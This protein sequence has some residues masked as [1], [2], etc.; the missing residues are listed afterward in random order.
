MNS[1]IDLILDSR[2]WEVFFDVFKTFL[3]FSLGLLSSYKINKWNENKKKKRLKKFYLSWISFSLE[4]FDRQIVLL[5]DYISEFESSNTSKL[6][7]NNSQIEKLNSINN[8]DLFDVFVLSNKGNHFINSQNLHQL[9]GHIEYL[10]ISI[11]NVK[12]RFY[13]FRTEF[14]NWN[15]EWNT[16]FLEFGNIVMNYVSKHKD[17]MEKNVQDIFH[18]KEKLNE[19][20]I[21]GNVNPELVLNIF[22]TPT[23]G[24]F[25]HHVRLTNDDIALKGIIISEKLNT[26]I[27]QRNSFFLSYSD[28]MKH[29]V[30]QLE[31]TI[32]KIR[33]KVD[34]F[35][36]Q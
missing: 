30:E 34:Y 21:D 32:L 28:I 9:G 1:Y 16:N 13:D 35:K 22:V 36:G 23:R 25:A 3:A 26:L 15:S 2:Y 18:Y 8:E 33:E 31:Y 5:K 6:M 29:Y 11:K 27:L 7:F 24:A 20:Y 10:I 19:K 4:S 14:R 17:S 12:E